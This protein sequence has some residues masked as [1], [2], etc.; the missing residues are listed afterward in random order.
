MALAFLIIPVV[1]VNQT[2]IELIRWKSLTDLNREKYVFAFVLSFF[3]SFLWLNYIIKLDIFDK[4]KKRYILL[5]LILALFF[6]AMTDFPYNLIHKLGF[7]NSPTPVNSFIYSVF[8]IGLIEETIKLIPFLIILKYTKAIDEP[9]DYI[10]YASVAALAFAFL[11]NSMYLHDYGLQIIN[12]RALFATVAH[13]VFS[14]TIAYGFITNKYHLSRYNPKLVFLFFFLIAIFSHGFYD[15]WLINQIASVYSWITTLFFLLGV[16]IWFVM[17][18]NSINISNY[19]TE[20][21]QINNDKLKLFL[22]MGLLGL[23]MFSYLYIAFTHDSKV[24]NNFF[25]EAVLVYGY[26]I[27]YLVATLTQYDLVQGIIKPLKFSFKSLLPKIRKSG[28][29]DDR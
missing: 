7:I 26:I 6:T 15:F 16:H 23:F 21:K 24:A 12:A 4:E 17:I 19:Y 5:I 10:L 25:R 18:N 29:K 8:G 20:N 22:I 14:S 2:D 13:M 3:I 1:L 27:F 9:Y 28:K 11:E